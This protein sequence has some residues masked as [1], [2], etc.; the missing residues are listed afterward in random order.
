MIRMIA[1]DLD[2]TLLATGGMS[3]P[4]RNLKALA[5]A[6][7]LGVRV[8]V[9][10]GRMFVGGQRFA[11]LVPGDQ[12]VI[13]VNGAV[14]RMSRSLRYVRRI[15]VSPDLAQAVLELMR[16]EG[17]KPWFYIGDICY[18]EE[19]TES[20]QALLNRTGVDG[21]IVD[22][23]DP[24]TVQRPEKI[25]CTMTPEATAELRA[26]VTAELGASLYIT[27][28]HPYQLEVLAP[29]ATKGAALAMTAADLDI[30][31]EEIAA[32]GDNL[33]DL[34]LFD[35]AGI[36]VAMGN[37]EDELK[38]KADLIAPS[39][40]EGGVGAIVEQLLDGQLQ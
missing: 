3:V 15:G 1:T 27:L 7:S 12:P 5:R 29:E 9:C 2:G 24:L 17:A 40:D 18:A 14:V 25:F 4:E 23:L 22:R 33:N 38:H 28:S 34:E 6:V 19:L 35:S 36:R 26:R 31:K 10:T 32:F 8:V 30:A 16:Q 13:C 39:N 37:A 11:Q 21:Q 20:L